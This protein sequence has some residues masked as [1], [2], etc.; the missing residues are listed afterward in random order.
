[1]ADKLFVSFLS[2]ILSQ[3]YPI[4]LSYGDELSS[5][6]HVMSVSEATCP[7]VSTSEPPY[8][9]REALDASNPHPPNLFRPSISKS[10]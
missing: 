2:I 4:F 1:M 8:L 10:F 5:W 9:P 3:F 6:D 7:P